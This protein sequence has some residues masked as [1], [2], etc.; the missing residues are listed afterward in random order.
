M[1][2]SRNSRLDLKA[3]TVKN[4]WFQQKFFLTTLFS[5]LFLFPL[6]LFWTVGTTWSLVS[7]LKYVFEKSVKHLWFCSKQ[8]NF[9]CGKPD[10]LLLCSVWPD[11]SERHVAAAVQ[12]QAVPLAP[13]LYYTVPSPVIQDVI[14]CSSS[15][16]S[17]VVASNKKRVG[18]GKGKNRR[19]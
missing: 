5:F 12:Q 10:K 14:K 2:P 7:F 16:L 17:K 9:I 8:L 19:G 13:S 18:G 6:A 1:Y 15:P 3:E 4:S 11:T